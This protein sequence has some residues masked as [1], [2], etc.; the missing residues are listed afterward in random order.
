MNTSEEAFRQFHHQLRR[1][2]QRRAGSDDAE[3][4]LQEVFLRVL[5]NEAALKQAREP[6]AWLF[7]VT[8]SVLVDHFRKR[9][10][11]PTALTQEADLD[12]LAMP[13]EGD[14]TDF[15]RCVAPLL[16]RL[17]EKYREALLFTDLNGGRQTE[18]A[19]S[20]R[21]NLSTAKSRVQRGR[22]LLKQALLSHCNVQMDVRRK[23]MELLPDKGCKGACC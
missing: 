12:V 5:R 11:T 15:G 16:N 10:R 18:L 14:E 7:V 13:K 22:V 9:G 21:I 17:P 4:I 8:R 20:L 6:L 23:V 1:Y 3:D 19:A 2:I